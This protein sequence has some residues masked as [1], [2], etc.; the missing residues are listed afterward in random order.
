LWTIEHATSEPVTRTLRDVR[1]SQCYA[2]LVLCEAD[3]L[4][5]AMSCELLAPA[6]LAAQPQAAHCSECRGKT[7]FSHARCTQCSQSRIR[8]LGHFSTARALS[9]NLRHYEMRRVTQ[10]SNSVLCL[11]DSSAA[12]GR[13]TGEHAM[14]AHR[15]SIPSLCPPS[16]EPHAAVRTALD[17]GTLALT[18]VEDF[19]VLSA[20]VVCIV[21]G[22]VL[23]TGN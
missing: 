9:K 11:I 17:L 10:L 12:I 8:E 5:V 1:K 6:E 20:S 16:H 15:D 23:W 13:V 3:R 4:G 14:S 21:M 19:V 2:R 7:K 22:Y 18:H